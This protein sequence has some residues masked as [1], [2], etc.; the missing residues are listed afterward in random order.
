MGTKLL[1]LGVEW[2]GHYV[3][4]SPPSSAWVKNKYNRTI[5]AIMLLTGTLLFYV[6]VY[7]Y[8]YI[9]HRVSRRLWSTVEYWWILTRSDLDVLRSKGTLNMCLLFKGFSCML[10]SNATGSRRLYGTVTRR[11]FSP[12][13]KHINRLTQVMW[14][15]TKMPFLSWPEW[16]Q[17]APTGHMTDPVT[18]CPFSPYLK[19]TH[20][21]K[22]RNP[23]VYK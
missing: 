23:S 21:M 10:S 22:Y 12:D 2:P 13:L 14:Y 11:S 5:T 6:C 17:K 16:Y 1:S 18:R 8:I 4:H 19:H 15:C 7:I 3:D 20:T 9:K